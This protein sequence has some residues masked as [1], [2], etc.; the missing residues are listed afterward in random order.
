MIDG[1]R[2]NQRVHR[3]RPAGEQRQRQ[4]ELDHHQRAAQAEAPIAD[5]ASAFLHRL[6][7]ARPRCLPRRRQPRGDAR[8]RAHREGEEQHRDAQRDLGLGRQRERRHQ[9]DDR[10]DDR[11]GE[12]RTEQSAGKREDQ[13][14]DEQLP[15]D[16][17]RRCADGR[18][19]RQ[20]SMARRAAREQQVGDV[21]AG[22]EQHEQHR[23]EQQPDAPLRAVAH[24][25]V[26]ELLDTHRPAFPALGTLLL[27]AGAERRHARVRLVHGDVILQTGHHQQRRVVG[28]QLR[29]GE[30]Q[31]HPDLVLLMIGRA[32][33]QHADDGPRLVVHAHLASDDA[34][35]AREPVLPQLVRQDDDVVAAGDTL[36]LAKRAAERERMPVAEHGEKPGRG[37]AGADV[38]RAIGGREVDVAAAPGVDVGE[39]GRLP[40]PGR[41]APG[42]GARA[43]A[44]LVFPDHHQ[45]I[46]L[47]VRQRREEEA[48]DD[49]EDGRGCGDAE[50]QRRDRD[51]REAGIPAEQAEAESGVTKD[52]G[53]EP[54]GSKR[55]ALLGRTYIN[56]LART[57]SGCGT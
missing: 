52:G 43:V 50:R 37:E 13:A 5:R 48:V 25:V 29:L 38:L 10:V 51:E 47:V 28:L 8:Q 39:R 42:G 55:C 23:A 4:G 34:G 2:A 11:R 15:D 7:G 27:E 19:N 6:G 53:H 20:L 57:A 54:G 16:R 1:H 26:A 18:A 41:V 22:D 3:H 24:E 45:A 36:V 30:H 32:L 17:R 12:Q 40:F 44:L 21:R 49:A 35:I 14:F 56:E 46:G 31:R 33:P 9:R